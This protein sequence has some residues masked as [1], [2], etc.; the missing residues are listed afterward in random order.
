MT[1]TGMNADQFQLAAEATVRLY[2][3]AWG[4]PE[5]EKR[6]AMLAQVCSDITHYTDP[7]VHFNHWR[8][9][10]AYVENVHVMFPGCRI[11]ITSGIDT[12]HGN[13]RFH[14]RFV[15]SDGATRQAGVD[16]VEFDA[17]GRLGRI[18]GFFDPR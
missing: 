12:H 8:E 9:L 11:E 1:E 3:A 15:T 5:A 6:R 2:C 10:D 7:T 17:D 16:F 14:W 13:G 4:E 18:V